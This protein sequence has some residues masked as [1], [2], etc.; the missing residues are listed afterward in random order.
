MPYDAISMS[1]ESWSKSKYLFVTDFDN[2][3]W[4]S[5][6]NFYNAC[7][8]FD[9]S[10]KT[11]ASYFQKNE[12]QV[13]VNIQKRSADLAKEYETL[14]EQA[15]TADEKANLKSKLK[16]KIKEATD[17]Y[18]SAVSEYNP[19]KPITDAKQCL[20]TIKLNISL[21]S[22]LSKLKELTK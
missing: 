17:L 15:T 20:E 1:T 14:I 5:I 12:E 3:Q 7:A 11:N 22:A 6:N 2:N 10:V 21:P 8:L 16:D 4:E 9:E 18:I 13:R 19:M